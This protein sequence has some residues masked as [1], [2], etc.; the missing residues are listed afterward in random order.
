M[1]HLALDPGDRRIGVAISDVSG[2]VARPLEVFSRRSRA[3][4]HDHIRA[5]ISEHK[6][7]RLVIG[8]PLNM[9]GSE[10]HQAGW[11]RDYAAALQATIDIPTVLWDERLTTHEAE[12]IA[13]AQG[14]AIAKDW[15]DAVAAAV[16]LQSYLD[17]QALPAMPP[18]LPDG[19]RNPSI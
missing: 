18:P 1:R 13:R 16:I 2:L 4:D 10:G 8:L 7:E 17:T 11:V 19:E 5:L 14:R 15:I 6:I 9:D 12:G 3:H